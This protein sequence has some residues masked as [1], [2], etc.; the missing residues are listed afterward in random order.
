M[1]IELLTAAAF[2]HCESPSI[3]EGSLIKKMKAGDM[4]YVREHMLG[5]NGL[6]DSDIVYVEVQPHGV[7][8]LGIEV[9]GYYEE[10]VPT[11]SEEGLGILR[12]AGV[13]V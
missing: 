7:V 9:T 6:T 4:P 2:T 3:G 11:D 10:P 13:A 1:N 5:E 12:D 8:T